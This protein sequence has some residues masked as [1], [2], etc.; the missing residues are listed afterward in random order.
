M[1][2]VLEKGGSLKVDNV[3]GGDAKV[4]CGGSGT[5]DGKQKSDSPTLP[6]VKTKEVSHT[7][8]Q[9]SEKSIQISSSCFEGY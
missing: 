3:T 4:G 2:A 5:D 6:V 9:V 8:S 7:E 1:A